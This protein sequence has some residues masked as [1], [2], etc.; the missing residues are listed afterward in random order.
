[1]KNRVNPV[2]FPEYA[3][4]FLS[5]IFFQKVKC[6]LFYIIIFFT[7]NVNRSVE[8]IPIPN[9]QNINESISNDKM[10]ACQN[11]TQTLGKKL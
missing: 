8:N 7:G 11:T 2:S 10:K 5:L 1:M 3:S 6:I 9:M 4:N